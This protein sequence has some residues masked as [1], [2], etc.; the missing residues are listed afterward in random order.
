MRSRDDPFPRDR[1][2]LRLVCFCCFCCFA[3][4]RCPAMASL[5]VPS[6]TLARECPRYTCMARTRDQVGSPTHAEHRWRRLRCD[7][8]VS[9]RATNANAVILRNTPP[10]PP[11]CSLKQPLLVILCRRPDDKTQP[12]VLLAVAATYVQLLLVTVVA[13]NEPGHIHFHIILPNTNKP[14]LLA[15][16]GRPFVYVHLPS[17][18]QH[19]TERAYLRWR[20]ISTHSAYVESERVVR[21]G[22]PFSIPLHLTHTCV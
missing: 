9:F 20:T 18:Q 17:G 14:G 6:T 19:V 16:G 15:R 2:T 3:A 7:E 11:R 21:P 10:R 4:S 22:I 13:F 8:H 5:A 1:S 12:T